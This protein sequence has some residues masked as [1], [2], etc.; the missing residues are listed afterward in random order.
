MNTYYSKLY[1]QHYNYSDIICVG[2]CFFNGKITF[3]NVKK[4]KMDFVKLLNKKGYELFEHSVESF[5]NHYLENG[6]DYENMK[7]TAIYHNNMFQ[8]DEPKQIALLCNS[9]NFN[10]YYEKFV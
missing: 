8:M 4:E 6:L 9:E 10:R 1:Y 2:L 5:K 7:R 3:I